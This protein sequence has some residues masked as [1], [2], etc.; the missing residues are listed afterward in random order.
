LRLF[1]ANPPSFAKPSEGRQSA[2][3]KNHPCPRA[4]SWHHAPH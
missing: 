1:A 3:P 2:I 4:I